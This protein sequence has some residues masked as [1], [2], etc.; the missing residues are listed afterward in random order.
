MS[1]ARRG[2]HRTAIVVGMS[3]QEFLSKTGSTM[4]RVA[5]DTLA[6]EKISIEPVA[7]W[8]PVGPPLD[9][10]FQRLLAYPSGAREITVQGQK[11]PVTP[12]VMVLVTAVSPQTDPAEFVDLVVDT[13]AELQGWTTEEDLAGESDFGTEGDGEGDG[14]IPVVYRYLSGTY[15]A[16]VGKT[17]TSSVLAGWNAEDKTY[18]FQA[19]VTTFEGSDQ[20]HDD[21]LESVHVGPWTLPDLIAAMRG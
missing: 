8:Q 10:E 17:R 7:P 9:T 12:N 3:L 13:S 19:V 14:G 21:A 11:T 4:D 1:P 20:F 18:V 2:G 5:I 6:G 16:E 15:Q